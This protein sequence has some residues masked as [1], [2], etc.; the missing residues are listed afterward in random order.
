MRKGAGK[1][2]RKYPRYTKAV[3]E[4]QSEASK[5]HTARKDEL[6]WMKG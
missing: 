6:F 2:I 4:V 3:R 1:G 5:E